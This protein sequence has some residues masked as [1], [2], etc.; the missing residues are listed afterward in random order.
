[1]KRCNECDSPGWHKMSCSRQR[2]APCYVCDKPTVR[3][4]C[5]DCYEYMELEAPRELEQAKVETEAFEV[6]AELAQTT[7]TVNDA[8]P[9]TIATE[10][11]G[12]L[13][14]IPPIL[15]VDETT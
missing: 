2:M 1:M 10:Q 8:S 4:V 15:D 11:W 13:F 5:D 12:D 3:T 7:G 6:V 9:V 14:R